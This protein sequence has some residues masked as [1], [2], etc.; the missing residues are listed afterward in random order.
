MDVSL[1]QYRDPQ[2]NTFYLIEEGMFPVCLYLNGHLNTSFSEN[3]DSTIDS[4]GSF[5]LFIY[6]YFK[7]EDIDMV[8]RVA[9][10]EFFT[11]AEIDSF[12][13]HC[14]FYA[15]KPSLDTNVVQLTDKQ[16]HNAIHITQH[17][18]SQ[19]S[20]FTVRMRLKHFL[21][22][23]QYVYICRHFDF[24]PPVSVS[25]KFSDF[26]RL[27]QGYIDIIS[28]SNED[29]K[30]PF[31]KAIPDPLFFKMLEVIKPEHEENP[32]K[33]SKLRNQIMTDI[34]IETGIR[35]GCVLKLKLCDVK[36]EWSN[37][38]L[39]VTRTPKD[40]TD[41]RKNRASNKTKTLSASISPELMKKLKWYIESI[42]STFP[43][44]ESHDFIFISEKGQTAG[45]PLTYGSLYNVIHKL[46][47]AIQFEIHPHLLRHKWN[48]IFDDKATEA[49]HSM[50]EIDDLRKFAMGWSESSTMAGLYNKFKIAKKISDLSSGRQNKTVPPQGDI[51]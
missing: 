1:N 14:K 25:E 16:L 31:E 48:E 24:N 8:E 17:S 34:F 44:S 46:G 42:R 29:T 3:A 19:C 7:S 49:G 36:D 51:D 28:D 39:M 26:E 10:G 15:D 33:G 40:K 4:Y 11:K 37:P 18:E 43:Q 50:S 41:T 47:K 22:Y 13:T 6:R 9:S 12:N 2:G 35:A 32:W 23:I 5:L 30:D 20:A 21:K 27:I 45:Q 38:R